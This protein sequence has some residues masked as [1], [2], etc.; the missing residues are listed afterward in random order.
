MMM[1]KGLLDEVKSLESF[2][3]CNALNTVGYKELYSFLDGD[4]S[5]DEAIEKIK[6]NTRRYAKRQLTWFKRDESIRWFSPD[7]L[8]GIISYVEGEINH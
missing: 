7:Q 3:A 5:L 4:L 1:E 6:T 8:N 2:R